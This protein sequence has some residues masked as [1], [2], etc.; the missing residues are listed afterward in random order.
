MR[1]PHHRELAVLA[2]L[3]QEMDEWADDVAS[4]PRNVEAVDLNASLFIIGEA[5]GPKTL[6]VSGVPYFD[7]EG[8]LGRTG[9]NL[10]K[11]LHPL[12]YTLYPQTHVMLPNGTLKANSGRGRRTAYCTD[13]CPKFPG[14]RISK[15]GEQAICRPSAKLIRCALNRA[16]IHR[17]L[18][19]VKPRVIFLLGSRAY[20]YFYRE[21]LNPY[22]EQL[23]SVVVG[24]ETMDYSTYNGASVIPL[25]HPSPGS[26]SFLQ[27]SRSFLGSDSHRSFTERVRLL[28]RC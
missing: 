24:I 2:R 5:A 27:W 20:R 6:R 21:F 17:E 3:F 18:A 15:S 12:G 19:I 7:P 4:V 1:I 14:Y 10:E 28:L 23:S 11:L 9:K 26:P 13:I 16:F 8:R 25:L 22:P